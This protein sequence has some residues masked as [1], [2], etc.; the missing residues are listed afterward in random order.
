MAAR[1]LESGGPRIALQASLLDRLTDDAPT[2]RVE[3]RD[4]RAVTIE[5][6]RQSVKRDL[7]WLMNS[8]NL[9]SSQSL[10]DWPGVKAA[11]VNFGIPSLSG[12]ALSGIEP[13][14]LERALRDA[15]I[16]FEPRLLGRSL[17]V[18]LDIHEDEMSAAA[19]SF[20]IDGELYATPEPERIRLRTQ[21]DLDL[22]TVTVQEAERR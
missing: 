2:S 3:A 21:L 9:D 8:V 4:R 13:G 17:R 22:G 19:V 15:L 20:L 12:L 11:V 1:S 10:D 5:G 6:I 14:K 16:A 7:S 18:S